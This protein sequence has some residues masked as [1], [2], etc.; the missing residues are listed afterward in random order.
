MKRGVFRLKRKNAKKIFFGIECLLC[1]YILYTIVF[2]QQGLMNHKRQEMKDL[3]QKIEY[4]KKLTKELN[5]EKE[6]IN[7]DEYIE[8][9]AREKLGMV[10]KNEKIFYDVNEAK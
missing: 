7:T 8:K 2:H 6:N 9:I 3:E 1:G 4:E 5:K 10:K